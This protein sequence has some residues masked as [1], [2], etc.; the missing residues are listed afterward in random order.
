MFCSKCGAQI[1]DNSTF[2][3]ACGFQL[4]TAVNAEAEA[5]STA[6]VEQQPVQ[7]YQQPVQNYQ[8]PV[9][10][11]QQPAQGYQQPAPGYQQPAYAPT[12]AASDKNKVAAGLLGIFLGSLGIHKFYLGYNKAGVIM[13]LVTLIGGAITFGVAAAVMEII[14]L[15]EGIMYLTKSDQEFYNTYVAAQKEWF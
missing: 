2:C 13:L 9:Q 11:Y 15:I 5:A 12:P 8:Q 4:E 7:E 14:A 10:N 6:P 3:P 1:D